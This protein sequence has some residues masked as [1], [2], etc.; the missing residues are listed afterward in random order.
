[1]VLP[2]SKNF[3]YSERPGVGSVQPKQKSPT[4]LFLLPFLVVFRL[5]IEVIR[6]I[7]LFLFTVVFTVVSVALCCPSK[8]RSLAG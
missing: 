8:L 1:M 4:A 7:V 3:A 6:A 5:V 2:R